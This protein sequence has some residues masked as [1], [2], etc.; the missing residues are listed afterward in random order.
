MSNFINYIVESFHNHDLREIIIFII[1][2]I[3]IV[4]AKGGL[5]AASL[6]NISAKISIP[7]CFLGNIIPVPFLLLFLNKIMTWM[8]NHSIFSGLLR[9]LNQKVERKKKFI[10]KFAYWGLFLF[11]AI[12]VPGTGAYTGS[13]VASCLNMNIKKSGIVITIGT[14]CSVFVLFLV[15]YGFLKNIIS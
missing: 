7:I 15:Y 11:V 13:L 8:S 4:E 9:I 3:P 5:L 12:P 2:M 1:S 10:E 6:M 14:L